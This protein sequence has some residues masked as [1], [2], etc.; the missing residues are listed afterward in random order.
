VIVNDKKKLEV[1]E[2]KRTTLLQDLDCMGEE[3]AQ[4]R[5]ELDKAKSLL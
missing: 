5:A 1:L 3:I 4:V 2:A